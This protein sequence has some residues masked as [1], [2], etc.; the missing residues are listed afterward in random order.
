MTP[1]PTVA[2][3]A[4]GNTLS[5]ASGRTYT[6]D[7]G[8]RLASTVV[9][10]TG[11]VSFKYDPFGR[12]IQKSSPLGTTN[13]L[14]SGPNLEE[15]VDNVGNV[16]A[17]YAQGLI[18]DEPLSEFRSGGT[19]YYEADVLGSITSLSNSSGALANT[20]IYDSYG[21]LTAS[22]GTL[23]NPFQCTGRDYDPESGLRYY[24]TR[25]YD[26]SDGRFT[27]LESHATFWY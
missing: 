20:Y 19:S 22:T 18:V 2:Y 10:G 5:D 6:W 23:I 14:Y 11:T 24:R 17:R 21:N 25:Y 9:P 7:F 26:P 13:Y 3:D 27:S 12:R 1:S 8:N 4:N 16:L 15:E